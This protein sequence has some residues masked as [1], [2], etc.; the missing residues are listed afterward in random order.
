MEV[1]CRESMGGTVRR[2]CLEIANSTR[3]ANIDRLVVMP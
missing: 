2:L 3:A 1:R